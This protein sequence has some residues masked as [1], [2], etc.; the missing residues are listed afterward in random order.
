MG[1]PNYK[2][3]LMKCSGSW[4]ISLGLLEFPYRILRHTHA[5]HSI[6]RSWSM[7]LGGM[8]VTRLPIT[9]GPSIQTLQPLC[10]HTDPKLSIFI[11]TSCMLLVI[12]WPP[13]GCMEQQILT[14]LSQFV[15]AIHFNLT[16]ANFSLRANGSTK[17]GKG[18]THVPVGNSS[19][20]N[21]LRLN[22]VR[23]DY[24]KSMSSKPVLVNWNL[25]SML[26][27]NATTSESRNTAQ[28][29]LMASFGKMQMIRLWRHTWTSVIFWFR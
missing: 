19:F 24:S 4:M 29:A 15:F 6:L 13:L 9:L 10:Q 28:L 23:Q 22:V 26:Q 14:W 25:F 8:N 2:C 18:S 16:G 20:V 11:L 21:W 17:L 5:L 7:R 27:K 3:I 12:T 1:L